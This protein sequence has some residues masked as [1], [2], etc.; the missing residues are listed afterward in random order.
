[1][2]AKVQV[3]LERRGFFPAGGGKFKVIVEPA[4]KLTRLDVPERGEV[5]TKRATAVV[6]SLPVEIARRELH[7][8]ERK[9][10]VDRKS[11]K[12]E[13]DGEAH[14]PGNVVMVE[15]ESEQV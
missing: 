15:V 7:T 8:I 11:L 14:G 12:A 10:K 13:E 9:L 2:G 6:A 4:T 5:R 3:L 1:M